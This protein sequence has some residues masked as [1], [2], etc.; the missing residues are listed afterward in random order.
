MTACCP[1]CGS[2][3][4]FPTAFSNSEGWRCGE[5][6]SLMP[7]NAPCPTVEEIYQIAARLRSERHDERRSQQ[8]YREAEDRELAGGG[9][10]DDYSDMDD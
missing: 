5:C 9:R 1:N 4:L 8:L 10:D 2:E 6:R 7:K 3:R